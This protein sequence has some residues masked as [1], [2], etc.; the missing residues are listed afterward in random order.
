MNIDMFGNMR[1]KEKVEVDEVRVDEYY[2][3]YKRAG[4]KNALLKAVMRAFLSDVNTQ[5]LGGILSALLNY[6]SPF[7][8]LRLVNFIDDGVKG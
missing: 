6:L 2:R 1:D 4:K 8:L 5:F 3:R 7:I